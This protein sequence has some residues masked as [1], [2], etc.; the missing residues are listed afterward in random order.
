MGWR[1][2]GMLDLVE[3]ARH[4]RLEQDGAGILWLTLD[5]AG[6]PVNALSS[7]VL[8]ELERLLPVIARTG[9][10]GLVIRSGKAGFIAGADV[11]EFTGLTGAD[12][13]LAHI[14]RGQ[15]IF[16]QLELLPMPTAAMIHGF[17]LG[18]GLELALACTARIASDAPETRLGLPEV[19]L[20]I[21]PGFGGTVRLTALL[22]PPAAMELMLTGRPVSARAARKLGLVDAVVPERHLAKAAVAAILAGKPARRASLVR[23]L[24]GR[25]PLRPALAW[26]LRRK[27]AQRANPEHYPAPFALIDLWSRFGGQP[28]AMYRAEAESVA[29][30]V[31]GATARNLVRVFQLQERLKGL[32]RT[33][34]PEAR[35]VHVVGG[36]AMGG[37]IAAWCALQGLVVTVQDVDAGRLA[38][39]V[40][41]AA[42]LFRRKLK[43]PRDVQAALDR[44]VPDPQGAG[45]ARADV[46]IEA[47][48]EDADAKTALYRELEP[49][50]K[51]DAILATNTSSIPLEQLA[52]WL[53]RPERFVGLHF[54][55]P[56]ARMLLVEVVTMAGSAQ[57]AVERATAFVG[58]IRKLPLPVKSSPGFLVNRILMP[59]LMEALTLVGEGVGPA[60]IDR[61][62]LAFGMPMGPVLL[63]DTVGLDICLSVAR[64]LGGHF[65]GA[66]PRRLEEMVAAGHLG[67]KTGQGFYRF[68]HGNPVLPKGPMPA[69]GGVIERR[70]MLRLLNEAVACLRE[71][72]TGDEDLLDAGV[73]FGTGFA[74][75]RGGP[76]CYNRQEGITR[77]ERQLKSLE[78]LH[79]NR[80]S[81]D[82]G[83]SSL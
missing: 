72:V 45:A 16:R 44:L 74:P 49:R 68:Q 63:A 27:V 75:F 10:K 46:V 23:R 1:E 53:E 32:A 65:G 30:L 17:C 81:P 54:F 12:Q 59:Y 3:Q 83:W 66:V 76:L 8:A 9:G 4:W 82:P 18:G 73:I 31:T 43:Q 37:D 52:A 11:G 15:E 13:A 14:R 26:F 71:R 77:Q 7:E 70:L 5:R 79:G 56:V 58:A 42:Q 57:D 78:D 29:R 22:G 80:F 34:W 61:A 36:G 33:G 24:P 39:V 20:G 69:P 51:P 19:Q 64:I 67:K 60:E 48:F 38:Q 35:F 40:K 50:M 62:A 28:E 25:W 41:R 2:K 55:N 47:I 6:S 21:H